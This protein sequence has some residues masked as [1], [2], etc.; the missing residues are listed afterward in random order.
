MYII[1]CKSA[2]EKIVVCNKLFTLYD[3]DRGSSP[4]DPVWRTVFSMMDSLVHDA[5][6]LLN[7]PNESNFLYCEAYL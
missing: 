4:S 5:G 3:F 1:I 7:L 2:W 6:K